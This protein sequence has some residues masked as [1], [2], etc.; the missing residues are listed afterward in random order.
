MS[1]SWTS[2]LWT[3]D[4]IAKNLFIA[5]YSPQKW[6][7]GWF[8][9]LKIIPTIIFWENWGHN[10]LLL[11]I[12]WPLTLPNLGDCVV[13]HTNFLFPNCLHNGILTIIR[14]NKLLFRPEFFFN[15]MNRILLKLWET[16]NLIRKAADFT[17]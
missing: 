16:R 13:G 1:M 6:T 12:V 14:Q 17:Y 3:S 4:E 9:V 5:S 15:N 2:Q 7:L 10:N 11:R 8:Y